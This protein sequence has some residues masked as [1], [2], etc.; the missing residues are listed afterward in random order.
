[1]SDFDD[2]QPDLD[3]PD[4]VMPPK[5]SRAVR[6]HVRRE[7]DT[8]STSAALARVTA[9]RDKVRDDLSNALYCFDDL[10]S[11]AGRKYQELEGERDAAMEL[12]ADAIKR[13]NALTGEPPRTD[14]KD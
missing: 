9:E 11:V 7:S 1:V 6:V 5:S 8:E 10:Q 4:M 13:L 3:P 12:Y 2:L 14:P